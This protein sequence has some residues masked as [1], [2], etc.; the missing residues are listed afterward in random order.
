MFLEAVV[1]VMHV[2]GHVVGHA[3]W[4]S[5]VDSETKIRL[6]SILSYQAVIFRVSSACSTC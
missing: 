1:S 3:C 4:S 6:G 2:V 5:V